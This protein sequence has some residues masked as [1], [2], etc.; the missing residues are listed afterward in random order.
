MSVYVDI[1]DA[2]KNAIVA[3]DATC[4]SDNV[5]TRIRFPKL[6]DLATYRKY[7]GAKGSNGKDLFHGW[8][9]TRSNSIEQR[10]DATNGSNELITVSEE[11]LIEG[12]YSLL[13]GEDFTETTW[14]EICDSVA[15]QLRSHSSIESLDQHQIFVDTVSLRAIGHTYLAGEWLCHTTQ[16]SL[17]FMQSNLLASSR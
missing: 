3:G 12:Y 13:D 14:Q 2:I 6:K 10:V 1:K 11:W 16:I 8:Q 9:M 4:P 5:H 15:G 7:F 17:R